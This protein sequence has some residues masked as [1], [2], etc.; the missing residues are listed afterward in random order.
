MSKEWIEIIGKILVEVAGFIADQFKDE[1]G[2]KKDDSK[3]TS[4]KER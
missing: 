1:K 4:E 2:D 3:G